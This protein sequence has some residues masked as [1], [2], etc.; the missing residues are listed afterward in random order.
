MCVNVPEPVHLVVLASGTGTTLQALID[1]SDLGGEIVAVGSD[2]AG[3]GALERAAA[4][5]IPT[6]VV[7]FDGY[8]D[9]GDWNRAFQAALAAHRPDLVVLAGFLRIFDP[10]LVRAFRIVNTHPS[11]LPSFPG[12]G[13]RAVRA[14]LAHGVKL[15]GATVHWVTEDVDSGPILAQVAVPVYEDDDEQSLFARIQLA[16]K[17]LYVDTIRRLCKE[18]SAYE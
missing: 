15:A 14:A 1:A 9:R 7:A 6:F 18:I 3:T 10:Q 8:P 17:P 13:V 12:V 16:E 5:E 11:L 4:A 2:R